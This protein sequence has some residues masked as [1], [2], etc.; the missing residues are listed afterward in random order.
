M[1]R[2]WCCRVAAA[3]RH[4]VKPDGMLRP[5]Q[6][7]EVVAVGDFA[8]LQPL[9]GEP[10]TRLVQVEKLWSE[11]LG[12]RSRMLMCCKRFYRPEVSP[13]HALQSVLGT[14]WFSLTVLPCASAAVCRVQ[15]VAEAFQ[16]RR[17]LIGPGSHH[18]P[19]AGVPVCGWGLYVPA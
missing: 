1:W 16:G 11:A 19:A 6:G 7:S 5:V 18:L 15:N 10:W 3:S 2:Q 9:P 14:P 17:D 8:E 13:K 4:R 12:L